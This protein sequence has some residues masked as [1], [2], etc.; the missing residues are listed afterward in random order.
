MVGKPAAIQPVQEVMTGPLQALGGL[1]ECWRW[2]VVVPGQCDKAAV[3]LFEQRPCG[4][5]R[6]LESHVEVGRQPQ[7]DFV[8]LNLGDVGASPRLH[9]GRGNSLAISA[10]DVRPMDSSTLKNSV[11]P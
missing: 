3:S 5:G 11:R 2:R 10:V 6:T 1:G 9:G 7:F 8:S 4:D